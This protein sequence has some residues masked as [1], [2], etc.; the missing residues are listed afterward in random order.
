MS[1]ETLSYPSPS[2]LGQLYLSPKISNSAD[3]LFRFE[4][5]GLLIDYF[6]LEASSTTKLKGRTILVDDTNPE[7][8]WSGNWVVRTNYSLELA[9]TSAVYGTCLS[10]DGRIPKQVRPHGNAIHESRSQGDYFTFQFSGT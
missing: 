8:Q 4:G 5:E 3:A 2:T 1:D 6:L 9:E 10:D 7:I